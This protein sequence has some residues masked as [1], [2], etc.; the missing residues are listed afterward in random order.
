MNTIQE[1]ISEFK[2][3]VFNTSLSMVKD[4]QYAEDISQEVFMDVYQNLSKFRGDSS[5][6]TWIY[7]LT[8]NKCLQHIRSKNTLKRKSETVSIKEQILDVP[9]FDHPGVTLENKEL[10]NTLMRAID[11]L[12]EPQRVAF[13]LH[14]IERLSHEEISAIM[15][16]S[17]SSI[18]SLIH[19]AK[20]NLRTNLKA[21]YE[22]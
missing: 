3:K 5:L 17:K 1:I 18:E 12:P 6:S 21:Y 2:D 13:T 16:K 15:D 11:L 19:R 4:Y 9:S 10:A 22:G 14:K 8:I 7:K 20:Q